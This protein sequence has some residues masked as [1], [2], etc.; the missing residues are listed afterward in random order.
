MSPAAETISPAAA[1]KPACR[2]A[3]PLPPEGD[4]P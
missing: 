1:P 2:L 4:A 3:D